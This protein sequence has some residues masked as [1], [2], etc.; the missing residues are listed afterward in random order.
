MTVDIH[1]MTGYTTEVISD[2]IKF[3]IEL[4]NITNTMIGINL[5]TTESIK[6]QFMDHIMKKEK[7]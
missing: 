5:I 2:L 6:N 4:M 7:L 3:I 1:I